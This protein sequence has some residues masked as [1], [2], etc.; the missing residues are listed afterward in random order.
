MCL[1]GS[2]SQRSD[3]LFF[4]IIDKIKVD[5]MYR[6]ERYWSMLKPCKSCGTFKTREQS[7]TVASFLGHLVHSDVRIN[8]NVPCPLSQTIPTSG[9]RP[10][11]H[12]L[13]IFWLW[14]WHTRNFSAERSTVLQAQMC[15]V[16]AMTARTVYT[17]G[18]RCN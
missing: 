18:R 6:N 5:N 16:A 11:S 8:F 3:S 14:F 17:V 4:T 15:V 10:S 12:R 9:S 13:V 7:N 1:N 2:H